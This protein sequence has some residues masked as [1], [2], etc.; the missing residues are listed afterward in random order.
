MI[1]ACK[2]ADKSNDN[3]TPQRFTEE[4]F[5]IPLPQGIYKPK[6]LKQLNML[7]M[8][9]VKEKPDF[10]INFDI[11]DFNGN[12][13]S[14]DSVMRSTEPY[15]VQFYANDS[16]RVVEGVAFFITKDFQNAIKEWK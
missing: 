13:V 12:L 10:K 8:L 7:E 6:G 5:R 1:L 15:F 14:A 11:K 4:H 3:Y 9:K 16:G 2:K